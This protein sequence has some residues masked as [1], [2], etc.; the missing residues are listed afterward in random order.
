MRALR[1]RL[2]F[3]LAK[4]LGVPIAVHQSFFAFGKKAVNPSP[5]RPA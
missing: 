4:L 5:G 3:Q 2:L 1:V